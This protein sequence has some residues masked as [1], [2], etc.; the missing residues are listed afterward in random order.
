[1]RQ[2]LFRIEGM[3]CDTCSKRVAETLRRLP[4]VRR[5][6]VNWESGQC[7][8]EH[9]ASVSIASLEQAITAAAKGTWHQ[10]KPTYL[11]RREGL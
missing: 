6:Q 2:T 4:G 7:L 1:M 3:T 8:V 9:E 5:V 10:Y 11:G